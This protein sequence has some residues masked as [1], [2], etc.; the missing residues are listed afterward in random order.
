MFPVTNVT[1]QTWIFVQIQ[2]YLKYSFSFHSFLYLH[3]KKQHHLSL[4][5]TAFIQLDL[6]HDRLT[7]KQTGYLGHVV[8]FIIK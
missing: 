6:M 3:S 4:H 8:N 7:S 5:T 1:N 2:F